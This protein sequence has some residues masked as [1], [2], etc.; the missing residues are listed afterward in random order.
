M[1]QSLSDAEF[2]VDDDYDYSPRNQVTADNDGLI[3]CNNHVSML[4]SILYI[5]YAY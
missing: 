3:A 4:A 1:L 2:R 5:L